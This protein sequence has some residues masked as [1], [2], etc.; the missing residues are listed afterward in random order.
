[1]EKQVKNDRETLD[2]TQM[3]AKG[4]G[5]KQKRNDKLHDP[6]CTGIYVNSIFCES[7]V[8]YSHSEAL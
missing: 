5:C 8:L 3:E 7:Y 6:T 1:M 4:V 2:L